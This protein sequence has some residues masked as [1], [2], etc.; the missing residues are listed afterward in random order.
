MSS[1][2]EAQKGRSMSKFSRGL[3]ALGSL[4]ALTSGMGPVRAA[5][6]LGPAQCDPKTH[7][8]TT[9]ITNQYAPMQTGQV[10]KF[11]GIDGKVRLG[12]E[13]KVLAGT[14]SFNGVPTAVVKET[15]WVDKDAD[16]EVGPKERLI[17]ISH[18][19]F[20]QTTNGGDAGTVC[21]FGESVQI[22][23]KSGKFKGD[24]TGSWRADHPGNAPGIFMPANPVVG[25]TYQMEFAPGVA[26]DQLTVLGF[27]DDVTVPLNTYD[28]VLRVKES[29]SL[30][31]DSDFKSYAPGVGL[32]IDE[33]LELTD[34]DANG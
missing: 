7:N 30:D 23:E 10:S 32:I 17:E 4:V 28:D 21:Y 6:S 31:G 19:Y 27:D 9:D 29:S 24:T 1:Q 14:E 5:E 3:V 22:F 20:A 16:G 34:F 2:E 25:S 18:N 8:F 13:I 33:V 11:F 26:E 12:L 15:E